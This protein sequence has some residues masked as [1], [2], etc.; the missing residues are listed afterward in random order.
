MQE[1]ILQVVY[2]SLVCFYFT[3]A[4]LFIT[5]FPLSS[6]LIKESGSNSLSVRGLWQWLAP[7]TPPVPPFFTGDRRPEGLDTG[8]EIQQKLPNDPPSTPPYFVSLFDPAKNIAIYS[9][10]KVTPTQAAGIG[11]YGRGAVNGN[12]RNP[13]GTL[14]INTLRLIL[15]SMDASKPN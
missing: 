9:A 15:K 3:L 4:N 8:T 2:F 14:N 10:Y 1:K 12:W 5:I 7:H 6:L 13:T 11:T